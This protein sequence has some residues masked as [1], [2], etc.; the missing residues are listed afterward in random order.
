MIFENVFIALLYHN[1]LHAILMYFKI[2]ISFSRVSKLLGRAEDIH[3][4]LDLKA[5]FRYDTL[6]LCCDSGRIQLLDLLD[7]QSVT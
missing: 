7:K 2:F 3:L 4:T 1:F 5:G 6:S